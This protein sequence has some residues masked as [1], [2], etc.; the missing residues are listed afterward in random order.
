MIIEDRSSHDHFTI[1][2]D[3]VIAVARGWPKALYETMKYVAKDNKKVEI[4]DN[5]LIELTGCGK[6]SFKKA[7]QF[8]LDQGWVSKGKKKK[9]I[10]E[11]RGIQWANTYYLEEIVWA[12]NAEYFSKRGSKTAYIRKKKTMK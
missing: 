11:K 1:I 8:L 9:V 6:V 12:M 3:I 10:T 4:G 2:P 5:K 7:L